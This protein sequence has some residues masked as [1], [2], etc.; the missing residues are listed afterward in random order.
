[1]RQV[2]LETPYF[3]FNGL[4]KMNLSDLIESVLSRFRSNPYPVKRLSLTTQPFTLLKTIQ[5]AGYETIIELKPRDRFN[6][7][8]LCI[9]KHSLSHWH[10]EDVEHWLGTTKGSYRSSSVVKQPS[11]L[12]EPLAKSSVT[13]LGTQVTD[14]DRAEDRDTLRNSS[15]ELDIHSH[16]DKR[17]PMKKSSCSS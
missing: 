14:L 9:D 6:E 13:I 8:L 15:Q 2:R 7:R 1:M 5:A 17:L 4:R 16:Q 3:L 12:R 11:T 10:F